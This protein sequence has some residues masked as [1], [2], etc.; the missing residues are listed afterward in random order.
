MLV[1]HSACL[2]ATGVL[3]YTLIE[4]VH[5]RWGGH[6]KLGI[7]LMLAGFLALAIAGTNT[8]GL[9]LGYAYSEW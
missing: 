8:V 1:L 3:G 9:L 7:G 4:Y 6:S 2:L 5:H